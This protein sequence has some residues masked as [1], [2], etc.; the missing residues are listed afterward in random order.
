LAL[1]AAVAL[2]CGQPVGFS[3]VPTIPV[4]SIS[5]LFGGD[6]MLGRGVEPLLRL[7]PSA[8]LQGIRA[9]VSGVDLALANLESPLTTAPHRR[10]PHA[11]EADP[12]AA[13]SLAAAGFDAVSVANNHAADAGRGTVTDTA[14]ALR[15]V[16][17][18]PVGTV[19]AGGVPVIQVEQ[20]GGLRIALLAFHASGRP[21]SGIAAWTPSTARVAVESAARR[22]H[23]V[24]VSVH[25][26]LPYRSTPDPFLTR[27]SGRLARW[28]ADVVWCHGPHVAQPVRVIDPD[29]DGRV[30]VAATSLGNLLFDE[31]GIPG[32]DHGSILEV[33]VTAEGVVAYREG[34]I[35]IR[36][37]RARLSG[38]TAP[39]GDAVAFDGGWWTPV[40]PIVVRERP[41]PVELLADLDPRWDVEAATLGDLDA[42]GRDE[43]VVTYRSGFRSWPSYEWLARPR[44]TFRD[45]DGRA[46][47]LAV[48]DE[49]LRPR[50][51]ASVVI[52]PIGSLAACGDALAVGYR[53]LDAR[54]TTSTGLWLWRA[55]GFSVPSNLPG[56][57]T[58]GCA[59]VD[60][61]R[62]P[63]PVITGR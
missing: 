25:G 44:A 6:V 38:W 60:G 26:G 46:W 15:T 21:T 47:H 55:F 9:A 52:R 3:D 31:Q 49:A 27:V 17:I 7:D 51:I 58:P 24:A 41:S 1:V 16:D 8:P 57:G 22:A 14:A 53:A 10:G 35:E 32:T 54:A 12:D 18:V 33:R 29:G 20:V 63:E 56:P 40:V 50:W 34:R 62:E 30:T 39:A 45:V 2:A 43:L 28:G 23:V 61:D 19:S 11:L 48:L 37:S 4:G 42:D 13:H 36:S 5:L 59:D